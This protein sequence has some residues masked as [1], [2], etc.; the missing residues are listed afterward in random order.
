MAGYSTDY[1]DNVKPILDK[2][3]AM[4]TPFRYKTETG[5]QLSV[6]PPI[7]RGNPDE[8]QY[9]L[10]VAHPNSS[11]EPRSMMAHREPLGNDPSQLESRLEEFFTGQH[12]MNILRQQQSGNFNSKS[13]MAE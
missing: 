11:S 10:T 1:G 5:H 9:R 12:G 2:N 3:F 8:Q 13:Y 6:H 4:K 7:E